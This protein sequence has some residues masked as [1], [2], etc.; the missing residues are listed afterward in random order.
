MNGEGKGTE[1]EENEGVATGQDVYN[2]LGGSLDLDIV[3]G[4][5]ILKTVLIVTLISELS[6]TS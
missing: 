4:R 2:Y 5:D 3:R 1:R 6:L